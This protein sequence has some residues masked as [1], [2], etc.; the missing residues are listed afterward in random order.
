MPRRLAP[1]RNENGSAAGSLM[2]AANR[3]RLRRGLGMLDVDP[4][5]EQAAM[6]HAQRMRNLDF[7]AHEDPFD[8]TSLCERLQAVNA[9]SPLWAGENLALCPGD[10]ELTVTLWLQ[11]PGHRAN[12]LHSPTTHC[13]Q[14]GARTTG[15]QMFWV[16]IY[17][18]YP[19]PRLCGAVGR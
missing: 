1:S 2:F 9:R 12:L 11:S 6:Q 10:P 3:S 18:L 16:Q 7:F 13:G 4:R 15:G 5:L 19:S 17:A 8:G 14:A